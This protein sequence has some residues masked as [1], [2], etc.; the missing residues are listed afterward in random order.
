MKIALLGATGNVGSRILV[1]AEN[2]GHDITA[3]ARR[4]DT[5]APRARVTPQRGDVTKEA[6]LVRLLS[7]HD[8]VISAIKFFRSDA[9]LV[10]RAVK[11]SVVSRLLVVGGAA[12]LEVAPGVALVDTPEFPEEYKKEALAGRS[13]LQALRAET[14]LQWTFLSP[15]A[16][17]TPGARTAR[18]R[19]G[20]DELLVDATGQSHISIE[21]FAMAMIDELE[22]PRHARQRFTVGY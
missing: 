4:P 6:E 5:I 18:F 16:L 7:G 11:S 22:N 19:L 15:S 17:L 20:R 21:D 2:R 1:E 12:T 8:A 13:W 14:S 9:A 3:I 10:I